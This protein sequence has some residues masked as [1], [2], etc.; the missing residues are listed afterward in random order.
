[1][2]HKIGKLVGLVG[3]KGSGKDTIAAMM[4]GFTNVKFAGALKEMLT[5]FLKYR[6]ATDREI[7]EMLEGSLKE[8]PTR[9]FGGKTPRWAMQSLG[10]EWGRDMISETIW[11]DTFQDHLFTLD[12]DDVVV[13][14]VRFVNEGK[15]IRSLGGLIFRII[16]DVP[17]DSSSEHISEVEGNSI[18]ADDSIKNFGSLQELEDEVRAT[19]EIHYDY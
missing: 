8:V 5:A 15:R 9:Y 10:T 11:L 13:S 18:H 1:M 17:E 16:R 3:K 2:T 7:Y 19:L 6:G 12:G 4:P 14:D